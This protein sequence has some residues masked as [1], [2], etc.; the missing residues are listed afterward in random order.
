MMKINATQQ[1][2]NSVGLHENIETYLHY[3]APV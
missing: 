1:K 2:L 3:Y